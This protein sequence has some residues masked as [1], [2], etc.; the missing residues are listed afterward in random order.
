M[1]EELYKNQIKMAIASSASK[2]DIKIV[3]K[4]FNLKKYF[5]TIIGAED[6]EKGKPQPKVFL[7]AAG[8]L[9]VKPVECLVIEDARN[10]ILA[11]ERANMKS[12][13]YRNINSR[14]QDLSGSDL[15]IDNFSQINYPRI[16]NLFK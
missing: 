14:Y 8:R 3:V 10:G 11:A 7:K 5:D 15:T 4:K 2:R 13:G 16:Y 6:V 9:K 12:I 1:I